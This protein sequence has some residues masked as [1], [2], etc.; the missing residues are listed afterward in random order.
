MCT[1]QALSLELLLT[2]S[3]PLSVSV[4]R[5]DSPSEGIKQSDR[6]WSP[7]LA[8]GS[9]ARQTMTISIL[10]RKAGILKEAPIP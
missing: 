7:A 10:Q 9:D 1:R 2:L 5:G 8:Q 4:L 6:Q 3:L